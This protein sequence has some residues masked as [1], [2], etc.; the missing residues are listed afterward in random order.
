MPL[1]SGCDWDLVNMQCH[2]TALL[3]SIVHNRV[4]I[5]IT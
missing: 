2:V 1:S 3:V 4:D 5:L